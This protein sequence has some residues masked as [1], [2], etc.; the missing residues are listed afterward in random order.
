MK[1]EVKVEE[2]LLVMRGSGKSLKYCFTTSAIS[3]GE[4]SSSEKSISSG[5]ASIAWRSFVIL[6]LTPGFRKIPCWD[7]LDR[8]KYCNANCSGKGSGWPKCC[9]FST[10]ET[11][12]IV[13]DFR[14]EFFRNFRTKRFIVFDFLKFTLGSEISLESWNFLRIWF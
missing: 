11:P 13:F 10:R 12:K 14:R 7:K 1:M 2:S 5:D 6:V 9:E 3:Y 8:L 4:N